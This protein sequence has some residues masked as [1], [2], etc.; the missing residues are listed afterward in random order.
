MILQFV[1]KGKYSVCDVHLSF[2]EYQTRLERAIRRSWD[3]LRT[4][5]VD[6]VTRSV[7][8]G[9]PETSPET[10]TQDTAYRIQNTG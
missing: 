9:T 8:Y 5:T 1:L 4:S 2:G 3:E 6:A 10:R 7:I